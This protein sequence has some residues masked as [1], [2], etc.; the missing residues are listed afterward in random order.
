MHRRK[1]PSCEHRSAERKWEREDGVL[2]LDHLQRYAQIVQ[3]GHGSIVMQGRSLRHRGSGCEINVHRPKPTAR[4]G[5]VRATQFA[6]GRFPHGS[7]AIAESPPG[8]LE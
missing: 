3:Y 4:T 5:T 2:P 1:S 7:T 8:L 6:V